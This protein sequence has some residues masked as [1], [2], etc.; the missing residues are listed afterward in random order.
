[1]RVEPR[2]APVPAS[3]LAVSQAVPLPPPLRL[4]EGAPNAA[5]WRNWKQIWDTFPVLTNLANKSPEYRA[6][7]LITCVGSE[8]MPV[9]NALSYA[10]SGDG[11]DAEKILDLLEKYSVGTE[12]PHMSVLSSTI[13][14]S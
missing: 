11:K 4:S 9:V 12:I 6:S 1:M 10:A 14:R 5:T 2:Q 8:A 3:L 7:M 13:A